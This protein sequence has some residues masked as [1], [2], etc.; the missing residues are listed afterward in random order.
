[1]ETLIGQ[2]FKECMDE[3]IA[4]KKKETELQGKKLIQENIGKPWGV[5]FNLEIYPKIEIYEISV[6]DESEEV[7]IVN[8]PPLPPVVEFN[9]LEGVGNKIQIFF[10]EQIQNVPALVNYITETNPS[11]TH[12]LLYKRTE[13][14]FV[15]ENP[16]W[17]GWFY[18][19]GPVLYFQS[20]GDIEK[21]TSYRLDRKPDISS[22]KQAYEDLLENGITTEVQ[23]GELQTGYIDSIKTNVKYYYIFLS[24]DVYGL[25]S[26][27]SIIY[28][29]ELVEDSGFI[30]PVINIFD[31]EETLKAE[32]K[33]KQVFKKDFTQYLRIEPSFIQK[34]VGFNSGETTGYGGLNAKKGDF[35]VGNIDNWYERLWCDDTISFNTDEDFPKIKVRIRS[36]KTKKAFDLN[37]KYILKIKQ[38]KD[39]EELDKLSPNAKFV[40]KV[41]K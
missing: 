11:K 16:E 39:K 8:Y 26:Y 12:Q 34:I 21:I 27:P 15:E 41:T 14:E 20:Q 5:R 28:E 25:N 1:M 31:I 9:P 4:T 19:M 10:Q 35:Y 13:K 3:C 36:K 32:E 37:L 7:V 40:K 38:L 17:K 23:Y 29:V 22:V 6:R 2:D 30:Y 18:W 24:Q 33:K